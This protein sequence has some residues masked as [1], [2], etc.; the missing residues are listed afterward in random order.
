MAI[1]YFPVK[2]VRI[3]DRSS[4]LICWLTACWAMCRSPAA[5]VETA[6][7]RHRGEGA[8][9]AELGTRAGQNARDLT[10]RSRLAATSCACYRT[11]STPGLTGDAGPR[12]GRGAGLVQ[13]SRRRRSAP[14]GWGDRVAAVPS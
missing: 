9:L 12:L 14:A 2:Q 6:P 8:Q 7:L 11:T 3:R 4:A 1:S 5:R 13:P 10:S